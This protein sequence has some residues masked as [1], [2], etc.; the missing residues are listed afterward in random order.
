MADHRPG[1]ERIGRRAVAAARRE[2]SPGPWVPYVF[3]APC[4]SPLAV[5]GTAGVSPA[6][7]GRRRQ[8]RRTVRRRA[9]ASSSRGR[10]PPEYARP[11]RLA[12]EGRWD[13]R[14]GATR[15]APAVWLRCAAP[16]APAVR[17]QTARGTTAGGRHPDHGKHIRSEI[18]KDLTECQGILRAAPSGSGRSQN[19]TLGEGGLLGHASRS[20]VWASAGAVLRACHPE[21]QSREAR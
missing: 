5:P 4:R 3:S 1:Q 13:P 6:A 19:D 2:P 16:M 12:P 9:A 21:R 14:S 10:E 17:G 15:P 11:P 20:S 18:A 7:V 8:V